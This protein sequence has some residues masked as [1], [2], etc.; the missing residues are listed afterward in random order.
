VTARLLED[1]RFVLQCLLLVLGERGPLQHDE[2]RSFLSPTAQAR[3]ADRW[4]SDAMWSFIAHGFGDAVPSDSLVHRLNRAMMLI[5]RAKARVIAPALQA[6]E[7]D[8]TEVAIVKGAD[9][10][11]TVYP[12]TLARCAAD[13]DIVVRADDLGDVERVL[14]ARAFRFG[15]FDPV[16]GGVLPFSE[17]TLAAA[18]AN[19][20]Y[21]LASLVQPYEE[22]ELRAYEDLEARLKQA[23]KCLSFGPSVPK[24]GVEL[25]VHWNILLGFDADTFWE[26]TIPARYGGVEVR[27][28]NRAATLCYVATRCYHEMFSGAARFRDFCD[29]VALL[30]RTPSFDWSRVIELVRRYN[31]G[32]AL[33]YL[34]H[35]ACRVLGRAVVPPE[36]LEIADPGHPEQMKRPEMLRNHHLGDITA[37]LLWRGVPTPFSM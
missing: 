32:P 18:R 7:D 36:V 11:S 10:Q 21:E 35:H 5:D 2:L 29:V 6:L 16:E 4:V 14:L 15:D 22:P 26:E 23:Y 1:E 24:I 33:F 27:V 34:G 25:D 20:H 3:L 8:V 13:V 37:R 17:E 9:L 28:A 31:F 12:P 30:S 19:K